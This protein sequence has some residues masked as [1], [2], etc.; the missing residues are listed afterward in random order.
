MN[1]PND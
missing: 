1:F